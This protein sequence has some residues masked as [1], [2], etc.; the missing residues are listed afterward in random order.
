MSLIQYVTKK[1]KKEFYSIQ[2]INVIK[3]RVEIMR[4]NCAT[5]NDWNDAVI[6]YDKTIKDLAYDVERTGVMFADVLPNRWPEKVIIGFSLCNLK[7]DRWDHIN[8]RYQ[9][10]FG[11]N[12]AFNR[13]CKWME[14]EDDAAK[15]MKY[16]SLSEAVPDTMK[17][18]LISFIERCSKY[19]QDKD[20]PYWAK[21]L[22]GL[23][24]I[25]ETEK[26]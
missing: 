24:S 25:L 3:Q 13:A 14:I 15:S 5:E 26:N 4:C 11:V 12:V 16:T 6:K 18:P 7:Y 2:D 17:K 20:L 1:L 21:D 10:G 22:C 23:I 19:Y 8:G 9:K